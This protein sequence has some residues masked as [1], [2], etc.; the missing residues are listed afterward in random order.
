MGVGGEILAALVF[1]IWGLLL[2]LM[3]EVL[4]TPVLPCDS[5]AGNDCQLEYEM[6][7]EEMK[8]RSIWIA[9]GCLGAMVATTIGSTLSTHGFGS[10]S[11]QLTKVCRIFLDNYQ[12][13]TLVLTSVLNCLHCSYFNNKLIMHQ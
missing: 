4:H 1:P 3:I 13:T 5:N 2:A 9:V 11:E 8:E 10:V 6:V 12:N 7:A